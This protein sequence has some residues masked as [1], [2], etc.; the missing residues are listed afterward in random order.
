MRL[1]I[2][3]VL[4]FVVSFGVF[5]Q[6]RP[7]DWYVGKPIKDITFDG[8]LY[9][10]SEELYGIVDPYIGRLFDDELF[11]ELQGRLYALEYF[12]MI[13]PSA[14]PADQEGSAV[15]LKF[16]VDEKPVVSSIRF[17]GNSGVRNTEL[18]DIVTIKED[19][20]INQLKMRADEEAIR[21]KYLSK[22]FPDVQVRS[23]TSSR[24]DGS[25]ELTFFID[26][27]EK[28]AIEEF[29]FEGNTAFSE[30]TLKGLLSLHVRTI[31]NDG[32]FQE[33]KLIADREAIVQYYRDRGYIDAAVTD[34]G[35]EL[36]TDDKGRNL[37]TLTFRIYEG[38]VYTFGG[39]EVEGNNIFSSEQLKELVYSKEGQIINARR[40]EADFQR[41]ADLYYENGY[42]FNTITRQEIR[43]EENGS[44][45]Y[46]ISIVERNRAYIENII[47]RG[48]EKT[49]EEV[50]L[51]EIPMEP[52][53]VFSKTKL[54]EG[55]RNLYNLQYFSMVTPDPV[56]GSEENLMNLVFNVEEQPT[57]DIQFGLTFSG[58]SDPDSFPISGLLKWN[59]RN[60]LGQGNIFGVEV[61][62]S[63]DTQTMSVQYTQRWL[64][65]LPLSGGFDLTS[66]HTQKTALMDNA[67][68]FFNGDES[69]AY[70]DGFSSYDDYDTSNKNPSAQ[71]MM[72]YDQWDVS[73]GF[74]TGYRFSTPL[75]NLGLSGGLRT[76]LIYNSYDDTLFRPFDPTLREQNNQWTPS[77]SIWS[78]LSLDQR[79]VYY[80][81]SGGYYAIQ[82][83]GYYG[84][85]PV[86]RE[87]YVKSDTK[88]EYFHTL[89]DIPVTESFNLKTVFGIHSGLSFLFPQWLDGEALIE[90]SNK[91]AIDGM[92][93]ARGWYSERLKR[94][95]ALWENW[96]EL[97]TPLA[98]G[99]LALDW[100]IDAAAV[101]EDP[102]SFFD[103][104]SVEDF[105]FS[106]GAG[107]RFTI[108][109]F[110]FRFSLAKRFR[111]V[112][113]DIE[114]Q[115]GGI[116]GW[117]L[118]FV[119]SF[120]LSSY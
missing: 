29:I 18:L 110:P 70:P 52:G 88:A 9:V 69:Y 7:D 54:W 53:D 46:L 95:M 61:N 41:I 42:I 83:L 96:A 103:D 34:V 33:A 90:D 93:N 85:F 99:I 68:P 112:D 116:G 107:L 12:E 73:I 23:E 45:S 16:E 30:R 75:G 56:A 37:M 65:G 58:T 20:V 63:P 40:V 15:I 24:K 67:A 57:A 71:Y 14:I 100:F 77:N 13:S 101:K 89:F 114:W 113:G 4:L 55:M 48:N 25:L 80:D 109:Q 10:K 117:G 108:P 115:D 78:S 74:S 47:I 84:I 31:L 27:G 66:T 62:A 3:A 118:D 5:A 105:R 44:V 51:R 6:E 86:E 19:D 72:D 104:L 1:R 8:L 60:F 97:R 76:G 79:D 82:R 32:A 64:F 17:E 2:A 111:V 36:R 120:A 106:L 35:R 49:S 43:D 94:G 50:I 102:E 87:H 22:G 39:I 91:L 11:W 59:D 38:S 98:P 119:L 21:E 28:I 81:P 26:E 92:F